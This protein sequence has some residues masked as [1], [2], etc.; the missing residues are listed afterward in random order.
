MA[1]LIY[2]VLMGHLSPLDGI[3]PSELGLDLLE[4]RLAS[5]EVKELRWYC[6]SVIL[7]FYSKRWR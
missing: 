5:G 3:G 6:I 4:K 1:H 7:M 2:F